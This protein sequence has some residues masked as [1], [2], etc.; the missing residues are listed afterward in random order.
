MDKRRLGVALKVLTKVKTKYAEKKDL[1][2]RKRYLR[3]R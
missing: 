1:I 3:K 2:E